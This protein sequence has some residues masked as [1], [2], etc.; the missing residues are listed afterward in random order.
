MEEDN[1]K[2]RDPFTLAS[3]IRVLLGFADPW[4]DTQTKPFKF[5]GLQRWGSGA[6]ILEGLRT[7]TSYRKMACGKETTSNADFQEHIDWLEKYLPILDS[8]MEKVTDK[9]KELPDGGKAVDLP[10]EWQP[11]L[12]L[13]AQRCHPGEGPWRWCCMRPPQRAGISGKCTAGGNGGVRAGGGAQGPRQCCASAEASCGHLRVRAG[14]PPLPPHLESLPPE[15]PLEVQAA[16]LTALSKMCLGEAQSLTGQSGEVR[17]MSPPPSASL[18]VAAMDFFESASRELKQLAGDFSA[19]SER[20]RKFLAVSAGLQEARRAKPTALACILISGP[21]L[22][23]A[24]LNEGFA[25]AEACGGD[26]RGEADWLPIFDQEIAAINKLATKID[27]D[28]QVVYFEPIPKQAEKL[29]DPETSGP[30]GTLRAPRPS[31]SLLLRLP[32]R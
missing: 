24:Q 9:V 28:R 26:Q 14:R 15:R 17:S 13:Q 19:A 6:M 31:P 32:K 4:K 21:G 18:H 27:R 1:V 10:S 8:F 23:I 3:N 11:Q 2:P 22:A 16:V 5:D 20:L 7:L 29:P 12:L 30:G 25:V